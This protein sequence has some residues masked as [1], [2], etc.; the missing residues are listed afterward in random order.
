MAYSYYL[1]ALPAILPCAR[2]Q[3]EIVAYATRAL[4]RVC[5]MAFIVE[6]VKPLKCVYRYFKTTFCFLQWFIAR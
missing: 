6:N 3:H 2:W 4:E 1:D 5:P